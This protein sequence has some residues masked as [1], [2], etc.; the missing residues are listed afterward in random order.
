MKSIKLLVI[1]LAVTAVTAGAQSFTLSCNHHATQNLFQTN[2]PVSDQ[3]SSFSAFFGSDSAGLSL[4]A[5][6]D[7]SL[8]HRNPPLSFG[9]VKAGLDYLKPAGSKGAFYFAAGVSGSL[10]HSD[11]SAFSSLTFD[12]MGAFKT[13]LVPTSILKIQWSGDYWE[14]RDHLFDFLSQTASLSLDKYFETRTT[15]KAEAGWKY[16]YFLHP[17]LDAALDAEPVLVRASMGGG[18]GGPRYKGGNGFVPI[19]RPGGGGSGIQSASTGLLLAQGLGDRLGLSISG[20]RQWTLSGENPFLSIEE[21]YFVRNPSS[22]DFSW[23][24][25][26]W[27]AVATLVLPWDIELKMGYNGFD[28]SFPGIEVLSPEGDPTGV[29]RSDRRHLLEGRIEKSFPRFSVFFSYVHINNSSSDPFF[30]WRSPSF[31][32]GIEWAIPAGRKE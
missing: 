1:A 6:A 15:V 24:G 16:K 2:A 18:G 30:T 28:K 22:D 19:Y 23:D 17:F 9:S 32:G 7:Y 11:Y 25:W 26:A 27:S 29:I 4:F 3:I 10:F 8:F 14:Y 5:Q 21:F 12:L 31:L 20:L 13:Y